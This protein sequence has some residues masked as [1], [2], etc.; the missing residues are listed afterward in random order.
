M[1][2]IEQLAFGNDAESPQAAQQNLNDDFIDENPRPQRPLKKFPSL[3]DAVDAEVQKNNQRFCSASFGIDEA[4]KSKL[5]VR[6][7]NT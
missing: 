1:I 4:A 7:F 2:E 6:K 3:D 5:N